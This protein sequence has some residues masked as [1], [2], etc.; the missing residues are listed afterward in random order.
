MRADRSVPSEERTIYIAGAGIAGLTLA[1]GLARFGR[2]IVVLERSPKLPEQGAGVQIGPNAWRVLDSLGLS[3][4]LSRVALFPEAL[5]I[6]SGA[7]RRPVAHLEFG[8]TMASAFGAPYAV[9]H[10]GDLAQILHRACT[11]FA[12]IEI[13]FGI[14][15]FDAETHANGLSLVS[16][17]VTGLG[18]SG[19]AHALVGA[20]GVNSLTR[21]ALLDGPP[22]RYAGRIAWRALVP[23]VSVASSLAPDRSAIF[24]GHD[25][26]LVAYPLPARGLV[27]LVMFRPHAMP[28]G[29]P[30]PSAPL[31]PRSSKG[32]PALTTLFAAANGLWTPWPLNT[33]STPTW[34]RGPIGLI[35]DAAHA[36][37]PFQAQGAAM[38]IEDAAILAPRL[39]RESRAEDAFEAFARIRRRRIERVARISVSNGRIFHLPQPFA[40][41]RDLSMKLMGPRNH[42]QRL[43][44]LY[45]YDALADAT[46]V[47]L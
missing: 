41:A 10:R 2:P 37:L 11:R 23:F 17:E 44:W 45:G 18:R 19:R 47:K 27:N 20:D 12:N 30:L 21:T 16:D 8:A 38:G 7:A 13:L 34:H 9:L 5:D 24:L 36:M 3:D 22:A 32:S 43:A 35:G 26:H 14:R 42:V 1:L 39:A 31:L 28:E 6:Y 33:V 25:F 46:A 15:S 40:L 4:E 29:A